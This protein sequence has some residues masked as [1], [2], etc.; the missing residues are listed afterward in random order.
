MTTFGE[1]LR[2][3]REMRGVTLEE[4]SAST[5][6]SVRFLKALEGENLPQLPGGIFTPGFIRAYAK[7]LGLDEDHV[8]AEYHLLVPEEGET[9][10]SRITTSRPLTRKQGAHGPLLAVLVAALLLGSGYLL[11]RYARTS[12]EVWAP[13]PSITPAASAPA[14]LAP[15]PESSTAETEVPNSLHQ[16]S[17][18]AIPQT[19]IMPGLQTAEML[20]LQVAA[21]ERVWVAVDADGK[22]VFQ[23]VLAPGEVE[24][25][26]A[27]ETFDVTTGNAQGTVLTLNG[28]TLEP[29]GRRG[30]VK[31]VRLT[32]N[33]ARK[34]SP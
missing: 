33:D 13:A 11:Y 19:P 4:I 7:Y 14:P 29:L 30:E 22:M 15:I 23:R 12:T 31:T 16:Q 21:T 32:V 8:M 3:E 20:T 6:I 24:T 17:G 28:E 9:D 5:K 10:L 27:K 1:N 34:N 26:H 2:R 25:L 18:T